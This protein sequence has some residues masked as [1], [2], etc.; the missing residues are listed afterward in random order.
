LAL[1]CRM[2]LACAEGLCNVEAGARLGVHAKTVCRWRARFLRRQLE[3]L[4]DAPRPGAPRTIS[5]EQVEQVITNPL[6]E[7]PADATRWSTREMAQATG[8]SQTAMVRIWRVSGLKPHLHRAWKLSTDRQWPCGA[9]RRPD[10]AGWRL[11]WTGPLGL[12]CA[13]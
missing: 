3:G 12:R 11:A 8:M 6:E 13:R 5:D 2:V 7:T 9:S 1:C 10:R 4:V